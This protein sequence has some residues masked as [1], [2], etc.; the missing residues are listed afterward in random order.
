MMPA[1]QVRAF[2]L[3][4]NDRQSTIAMMMIGAIIHRHLGDAGT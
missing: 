1:T 4:S 3:R 2:D